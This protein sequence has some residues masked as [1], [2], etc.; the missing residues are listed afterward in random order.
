M[1]WA[2]ESNCDYL[3]CSLQTIVDWSWVATR[4]LLGSSKYIQLVNHMIFVNQMAIFTEP[5]APAHTTA[6]CLH[7]QSS[8]AQIFQCNRLRTSRRTK[9]HTRIYWTDVA[10]AS[11][12]VAWFEIL[13]VRVR[14]G[15]AIGALTLTL[16]AYIYMTIYNNLC[17]FPSFIVTLFIRDFL[18]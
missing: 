2:C 6:R 5:I 7:S 1:L 12:T 14:L 15:G 8:A 16:R 18:A 13:H 17:S 10:C 9:I 11:K 4:Y 3:N